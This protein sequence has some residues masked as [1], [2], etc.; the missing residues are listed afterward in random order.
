MDVN[1]AIMMKTLNCM[2]EKLI[3][4]MGIEEYTKFALKTTERVLREVIEEMEDRTIDRLKG[5]ETHE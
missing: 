5:G 4:L 3:E 1:K 2:E